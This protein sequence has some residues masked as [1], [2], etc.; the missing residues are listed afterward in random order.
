MKRTLSILSTV[1]LLS[2]SYVLSRTPDIGS[3][4]PLFYVGFLLASAGYLGILNW[5]LPVS[6]RGWIPL[7]ILL[8]VLPR[9]FALH[10]LCSDDL[11]RYV[12]E[13]RILREG[14]NPFAIPPDAPELIPFRD[15][16][17]PKINHKDMPAIY[18]PLTQAAFVLF[19]MI[20]QS[21][22]GFRLLL[23]LTELA[24]IA[25]LYAWIRKLGLPRER[26]LIYA[27]NPLVFISIAG[28]GHLDSLQV[29]L[30]VLCLTAWGR[31]RE[32][33]GMVLL[34]LAGMVKFLALF[35]L[36]FFVKKR[37]VKVLPVCLGIVTVGYLPFFFLKGPFSFGSLFPFFGQF[38]YYSLT[39]LPLR[40][41]FGTAGA[42][43]ITA[44]VLLAVMSGLWLTRTRPE[45]AVPPFLFLLILMNPTVHYWYLIPIL[46]LGTVWYSRALIALTILI[47]PYF[48]VM[49][50][51]VTE[52]VFESAWWRP[53]ITY[54]PFLII[55]WLEMSGRWPGRRAKEERIGIVIPVLNDAEPL[56]KL[57]DSLKKAAVDKRQVVV[58]DGG[59]TDE[60]V[61]IARHWGAQVVACPRRGR[62][63]QITRGAEHLDTD[64]TLVLHADN[65][66]PDNLLTVL[67]R[68]LS[69]YPH[70][71][72]GAFRLKYENPGF[73]MKLL[74]VF[75]N[76][77]AALF[78]LS[79][80]DQG[81]WF[82]SGKLKIPGIPLMEDVELAIRINDRGNPVWTPG[83]LKV[84][85]RRYTEKG[86]LR[87]ILS[88]IVHTTA[89]L[90][91][92]RWC[93]QVPD[94]KI[95]Y[96][97]YY[98]RKLNESLGIECGGS[99]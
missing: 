79:F 32:G 14:Y 58:A 20:T 77:K 62:G 44:F 76:A 27:L 45:V 8:V 25:A 2:G 16:I 17:Y 75:S 23:V 4:L 24:A 86:R 81:Q 71:C 73:R 10:L 19:S 21:M 3:N 18:P 15:E 83:V 56:K 41:C 93:D 94:T 12:W 54:L 95:L 80:G 52:G 97:K 28:H 36:P 38:E 47:L 37:T 87:V 40:W 7:L 96:E 72:G 70:A 82:R 30:L 5:K 65:V 88:V 34:T 43:A 69:A 1:L 42:Y 46:A 84:S 9:L 92:R 90:F 6:R 49:G 35:A 57:L 64:I 29:L 91:R 61:G 98:G 51:I 78:G 99:G 53:V 39:F 60:S 89:Y 48:D 33:F 11:A 55:L 66:V 74:S 85:T 13:G 31:G 68:A 63:Y 26:V 67:H 22:E 59:S 50:K